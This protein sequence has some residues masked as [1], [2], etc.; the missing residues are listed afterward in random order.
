[1][2]KGITFKRRT[3]KTSLSSRSRR[4]LE[5]RHRAKRQRGG[6][7]NG[8]QQASSGWTGLPLPLNTDTPRLADKS[9]QTL[10]DLG[11]GGLQAGMR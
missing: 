4:L 11:G 8:P 2:P 6:S 3:R 9:L 7:M 5:V 1:M 10:Y